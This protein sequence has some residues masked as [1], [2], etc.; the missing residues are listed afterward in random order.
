[1]MGRPGVQ[2][3]GEPHTDPTPASRRSEPSLPPEPPTP[4]LPE[5]LNL[6]QHLVHARITEGRG[7]RTAVVTPDATFTYA[8]V[9]DRAGRVSAALAARGVG[10]GDRVLLLMGDGIDFVAGLFGCLGLGA[11]AVMA[12]PELPAVDHRALL[13]YTGARAVLADPSSLAPL[14]GH[15]S[16]DGPPLVLLASGDGEAP[17]G[18]ETLRSAC[19]SVGPLPPRDTD[20]R[21]PALWLLT[22]G[23][24][25]APRA[26]IH[27]HRDFAYSIE[28]YARQVLGLH[29]DDVTFAVPRLHFPYA[30]GNALLFPFAVGARTVL[31]PER[32]TAAQTREILEKYRPSILVT[33]PTM[34]AKLLDDP[35]DAGAAASSLR[36]A[37]SAGEALPP[38]LFRRWVSRHGVEMLDGIGSAEM[39]HVYVSNR[40]GQARAGSLGRVVPG[41]QAKVVR[42]DGTDAAPDE[43]GTLWVRGGSAGSGYHDA[44]ERSRQVFRDDGWV[45]TGDFFRCDA[46]GWFTFEGRADDML[47]VAGLYV[48]PLEVERVIASHPAV[49]E[50]AV[51]GAPDDQGLVKPR[52]HVVPRAGTSGDAGLERELDAWTRERLP[53]YKVPRAWM[54]AT[55]LPR[56]DRGKLVRRT[57]RTLSG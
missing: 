26:V 51:V 42:D 24:T 27:A 18:C 22:S 35:A 29:Q 30:T 33:V 41:Y 50:C 46:Q 1:M 36:L 48:S 54:F 3:S 6:T 56:N 10:A 16:G 21:D 53:H 4:E 25:G 34:T 39:F 14:V 5:R 20:G 12:N 31:V 43:V 32:P 28:C 38:D 2:A 15:P 17:V 45:V 44:P 49:A 40:P 13:A 47:K 55:E 37:L 19:A 7:G 9:A 11:V 57:L 8:Q 23:S 52:A